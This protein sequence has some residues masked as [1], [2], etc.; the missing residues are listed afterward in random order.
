MTQQ[1]EVFLGLPE[2]L[3]LRL[4]ALK[5]AGAT[6][7]SVTTSSVSAKYIVFYTFTAVIP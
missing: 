4:Y 1:F 5:T 2:D 6:L 3:K 7:I